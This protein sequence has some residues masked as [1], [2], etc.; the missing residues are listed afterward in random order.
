MTIHGLATCAA[1]CSR[2]SNVKF[3]LLLLLSLPAF[4]GISRSPSGDDG[5]TCSGRPCTYV[6]SCENGVGKPAEIQTAYDDSHRGD[7]IKLQPKSAEG[8]QCVWTVAGD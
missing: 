4:A 3:I 7:T 6:I 1:H 2:G 8:A 5:K